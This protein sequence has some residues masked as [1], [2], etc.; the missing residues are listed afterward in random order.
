MRLKSIF[1]SL[2]FGFLFQGIKKY[3]ISELANYDFLAS[4][5]KN[6]KSVFWYILPFQASFIPC[7]PSNPMESFPSPLLL[8]FFSLSFSPSFFFCLEMLFPSHPQ[9]LNE[10]LHKQLFWGKS[11]EI[12]EEARK[13]KKKGREEEK[14]KE[15]VREEVGWTLKEVIIQVQVLL[16]L[17]RKN[18]LMNCQRK[19]W[20]K[21]WEIKWQEKSLD[22]IHWDHN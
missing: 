4:F 14:R 13:E 9:D 11:K 1:P 7:C 5:L 6:Y 20:Q 18:K 3:A 16:C 17:D 12:K 21:K 2:I 19:K 22:D 8:S 15:K 10:G